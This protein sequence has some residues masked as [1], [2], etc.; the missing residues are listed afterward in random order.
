M[1]NDPIWAPEGDLS[2]GPLSEWDRAYE[3][4]CNKKVNIEGTP[5]DRSKLKETQLRASAAY[6]NRRKRNSD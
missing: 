5:V 6:V 2:P 1:L 3:K 4:W